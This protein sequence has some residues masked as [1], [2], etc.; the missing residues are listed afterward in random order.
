[1]KTNKANGFSTVAAVIAVVAVV[2]VAGLIV[3]RVL[4]TNKTN[5]TPNT[6]TTTSQEEAQTD[7]D[8]NEG[9]VVIKEWGVRFKPLEGLS[10]V[11][12]FNLADVSDGSQRY[13]L[14]TNALVEKEPNC[15]AQGVGSIQKSSTPLEQ[16][17]VSLG[18]ISGTYYYY[19]GSQAAC[20][21][22]SANFSFESEQRRAIES[23]I[24][25]LE[26]AK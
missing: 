19:R 11:R 24:K 1:M 12:Y 5:S 15:A 9:Y 21:E 8:P 13:D 2:A 25:T 18:E 3:W 10:G 14:S 17:E 16:Y 23:S 4:D 7:T 26:A 22:N 6:N 20:S